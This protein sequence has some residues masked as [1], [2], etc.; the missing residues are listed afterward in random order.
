MNATEDR[1][2]DVDLAADGRR[3]REEHHLAMDKVQVAYYD[4]LDA[5]EEL[6]ESHEC[7]QCEFCDDAQ[8]QTYVLRLFLETLKCEVL[9][10]AP[11]KAREMLYHQHRA[12]RARANGD[13][14]AEERAEAEA[15][16]LD[17]V[18]VRDRVLDGRG[19]PEEVARVRRWC[20]KELARL[21][22]QGLPAPARLAA[23]A[24]AEPAPSAVVA[25]R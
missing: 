10:S 8:Q 24:E 18:L 7:D 20:E 4:L 25:C 19:T 11:V 12:E 1:S 22:G 6:L 9:W 13:A 23:V 21:K 16:H 2:A 15:R 14:E 17:I 5:V 3:A